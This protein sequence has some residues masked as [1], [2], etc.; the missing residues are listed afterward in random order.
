MTKNL[1]NICKS[2]ISARPIRN[3]QIRRQICKPGILAWL[4]FEVCTKVEDIFIFLATV[5]TE[6]SGLFCNMC[7]TFVFFWW[8]LRSVFVQLLAFLAV[9][10]RVSK[11]LRTLWTVLAGKPSIFA[12]FLTGR[13]GFSLRPPTFASR[14][15][16]SFNA[17]FDLK[18]YSITKNS[19][20]TMNRHMFISLQNISRVDEVFPEIY[21]FRRVRILARTNLNA[22]FIFYYL[23]NFMCGC[24]L[25]QWYA[26]M[27]IQNIFIWVFLQNE[28]L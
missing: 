26:Y 22:N 1:R 12:S 25:F 5:R 18:A 17:I 15:C 8:F 10:K 21:V 24:S 11:Y 3:L 7:F 6:R 20:F 13:C 28:T 14:T 2:S 16:S 27:K 9:V 19:F 23:Y 4:C